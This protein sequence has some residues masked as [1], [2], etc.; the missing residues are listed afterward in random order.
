[1]KKIQEFLGTIFA[2]LFSPME[3]AW[4]PATLL[5]SIYAGILGYNNISFSKVPAV[6]G[7]IFF[8]ILVQYIESSKARKLALKGNSHTVDNFISVI[9]LLV[10]IGGAVAGF[11]AGFGEIHIGEFKIGDLL[12]SVFNNIYMYIAIFVAILDVVFASEVTL[13]IA[14][15][16]FGFRESDA[17][18]I[19]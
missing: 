11:V 8:A 2:V 19:D 6:I 15:R 9:V 4:F 7:F 13:S 10:L 17:G 3:K 14:R 1:M 16:D 5:L 18:L 12:Q